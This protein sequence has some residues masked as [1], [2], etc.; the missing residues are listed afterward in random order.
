VATSVSATM[1]R[2]ASRISTRCSDRSGERSP[3]DT[4]RQAPSAPSPKTARLSTCSS[5][6]NRCSCAN[7]SFIDSIATPPAWNSRRRASSLAISQPIQKAMATGYRP[8]IW[9]YTGRASRRPARIR[10]DDGAGIGADD[11]GAGNRST[12]CGRSA[13]RLRP[14][15]TQLA[16]P[17]DRR[18]RNVTEFT[19]APVAGQADGPNQAAAPLVDT[20]SARG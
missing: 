11:T 8:W 6:T 20:S 5:A 17:A 13:I 4:D 3:R 19:F 12:R 16:L 14:S 18:A 1:P 9:R 15:M 2:I 10:F 7:S